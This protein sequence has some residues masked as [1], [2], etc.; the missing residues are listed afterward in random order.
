MDYYITPYNTSLNFHRFM[1]FEEEND[2]EKDRQKRRKF[3]PMS[4]CDNWKF[5]ADFILN[6]NQTV[7]RK[8]CQSINKGLYL[9]LKDLSKWIEDETKSK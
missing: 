4:V 9:E 5:M 6:E 7:F 1:D 8:S 3:Q 2:K